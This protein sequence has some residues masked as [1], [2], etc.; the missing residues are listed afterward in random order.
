MHPDICDEGR[1]IAVGEGLLSLIAFLLIH[2]FG[3][4]DGFFLPIQP[5]GSSAP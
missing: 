3:F 5:T 4:R 1:A 2:S